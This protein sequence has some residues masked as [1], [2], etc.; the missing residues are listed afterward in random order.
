MDA[1]WWTPKGERAL[2][3]VEWELFRDGL[4]QNW[5]SVE[6]SIKDVTNTKGPAFRRQTTISH[7][8]WAALADESSASVPGV[9]LR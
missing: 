9:R 2:R 5:D 1:M 7:D 8:L 3:G 6:A 4:D